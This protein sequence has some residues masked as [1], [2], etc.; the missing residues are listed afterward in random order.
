MAT[1]PSRG[2]VPL[3]KKLTFRGHGGYISS[4]CR[5]RSTQWHPGRSIG[6]ANFGIAPG[7]NSRTS[8]V[9]ARSAAGGQ[10][11]L[12]AQRGGP[13]RC[14]GNR[15]TFRP[16]TPGLLGP[17]PPK[18]PNT[19]SAPGRETP[20]CCAFIARK[21]LQAVR[22]AESRHSENVCPRGCQAVR[23][24][25]PSLTKHPI[26]TTLDRSSCLPRIRLWMGGQANGEWNPSQLHAFGRQEQHGTPTAPP[27]NE[28]LNALTRLTRHSRGCVLRSRLDWARQGL[29]GD[30]LLSEPA[31]SK[32]SR[33]RR[34]VTV[35]A[36]K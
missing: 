7:L 20:W 5:L 26:R 11:R 1:G 18:Q 19:R 24:G 27:H 25:T 35:R 3:L 23:P 17:Q 8:R 36:G 22:P 32:G 6:I 33:T 29:H 21:T 9:A 15:H 28:T 12:G 16:G 30:A 34:I 10:R 13:V 14:K 2:T 4:Q 31:R